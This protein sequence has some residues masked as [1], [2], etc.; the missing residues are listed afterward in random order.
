MKKKILRIGVFW[1]LFLVLYS[2]TSELLRDKQ[3]DFLLQPFY[4][5]PENSVDIVM[6]GASNVYTSLLPME[7]WKEFGYTSFNLGT[8][9]QTI[10]FSYY[11]AKDAIQTQRPSFIILDVNAAGDAPVPASAF[12]HGI[13]DNMQRP[14]TKAQAILTL[15]KKEDW[16][17]YFVSIYEFH[18]RWKELKMEDFVIGGGVLLWGETL[19]S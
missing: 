6:L 2:G 7:L 14:S 3:R 8:S 10:P 12:V 18:S 17:R 19:L 9:M 13:V 4:Q 16:F 5:L 15:T 1:L 11:L